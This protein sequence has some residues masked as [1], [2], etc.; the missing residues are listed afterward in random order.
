MDDL[1]T[2]QV[3]N[4]LERLRA[5]EQAVRAAD[6]AAGGNAS[7]EEIRNRVDQAVRLYCAI[8]RGAT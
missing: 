8:S 5:I 7:P 1:I 2:I 4:A 6:I 3:R